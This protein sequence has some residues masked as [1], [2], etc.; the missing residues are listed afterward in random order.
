MAMIVDT[1]FIKLDKPA[2]IIKIDELPKMWFLSPK[3]QKI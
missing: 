1:L 2:K 3:A